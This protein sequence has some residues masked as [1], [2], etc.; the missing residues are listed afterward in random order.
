MNYWDI[1]AVSS[2]DNGL[3]WGEPTN[4]TN[5]P[6]IDDTY[7]FISE[8]NQSG[9]INVLYQTDI[10]SGEVRNGGQQFV[11]NVDHLFL[12]TDHPSTM[13]YDTEPYTFDPPD[14]I[15]DSVNPDIKIG[16]KVQPV[17]YTLDQNYPNP[18]N[19][20]TTISYSIAGKSYVSI[21]IHDMLGR[22]IRILVAE[23]QAAGSH[24][25]EWNGLDDRGGRAPSGIYFYTLT[26]KGFRETRKLVMLR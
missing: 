7:P 11:G 16:S 10:L 26:A 19:P 22:E 21:K 2:A 18:F 6:R 9:K 13:P 5:T 1:S 14:T 15:I 23:D 8:W 25:T 4:L 24:R 20:S 12:Q 3:T 17:K